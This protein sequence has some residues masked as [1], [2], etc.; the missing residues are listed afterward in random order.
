M[1]LPERMQTKIK[2]RIGDNRLV[3][4]PYNKDQILTILKSRIT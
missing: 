1:D 4:Q 2:S 3:Y